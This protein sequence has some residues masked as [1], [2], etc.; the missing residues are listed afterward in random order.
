MLPEEEWEL[1]NEEIIETVS[2]YPSPPIIP[3]DSPVSRL[4][5]ELV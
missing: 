2:L 5:H 3:V 4:F 1:K